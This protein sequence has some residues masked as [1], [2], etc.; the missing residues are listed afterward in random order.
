MLSADADPRGAADMAKKTIVELTDDLD[1]SPGKTRPFG[2]RSTA[3]SSRLTSAR[4]M[5]SSYVTYSSPLLRPPGA[6]TVSA[7]AGAEA[8]VGARASRDREQLQGIR[9]WAKTQGYKVA[10]RGR[11]SAEIQRA[12][13][14][15]H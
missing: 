11:I 3:A 10:Q 14:E 5:P 15:A 2:L 13:N 1:G 12:Y 4:H 7:A 8:A 9:A 6:L